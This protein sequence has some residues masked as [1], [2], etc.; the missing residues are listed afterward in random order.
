MSDLVDP[1][2]IEQFVGARRRER[3][4]LARAVAV[5]GVI[6]ILHSRDCVATTADLRDCPYSLALDAG[7]VWLE[8]HQ[9]DRP[10]HASIRNGRL[11]LTTPA[12]ETP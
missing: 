2:R 8:T 11:L 1:S 6:Y 4:H 3:E 10:M 12:E 5:E 9:M 7:L